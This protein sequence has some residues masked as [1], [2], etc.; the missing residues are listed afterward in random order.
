MKLQKAPSM[1]TL[2]RVRKRIIGLQRTVLTSAVD[3][4]GTWF[5]LMSTQAAAERVITKVHRVVLGNGVQLRVELADENLWPAITNIL[6]QVPW[7]QAQKSGKFKR[8][9][10]Y[11]NEPEAAKKYLALKM[12][13]TSLTTKQLHDL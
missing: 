4:T 9:R 1:D 3:G 6:S 10:S 8:E 12:A 13:P 2:C 5:F 7:V 11:W